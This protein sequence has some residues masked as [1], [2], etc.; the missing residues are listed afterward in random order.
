MNSL[1][2]NDEY[3]EAESLVRKCMPELKPAVKEIRSQGVKIQ[4]ITPDQLASLMPD[5]DRETIEKLC[6]KFPV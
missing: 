1:S 6:R 2:E 5:A 3:C 4:S